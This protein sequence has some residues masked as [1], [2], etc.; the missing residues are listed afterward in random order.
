MVDD[1]G[2]ELKHVLDA[3]SEQTHR[4]VQMRAVDTIPKERIVRQVHVLILSNR[5]DR[6]FRDITSQ[7]CELVCLPRRNRC[8]VGQLE[9]LCFRQ[10]DAVVECFDDQLPELEL[11]GC[12]LD[13]P[14]E[15]PRELDFNSSC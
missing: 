9:N 6:L 10:T 13:G 8:D 12:D 15:R 3:R 11:L 5:I 14:T 7:T 4:A 1:R 2:I